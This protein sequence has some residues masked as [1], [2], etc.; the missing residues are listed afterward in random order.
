MTNDGPWNWCRDT[1]LPRCKFPQKGLGRRFQLQTILRSK[2]R[3]GPSLRAIITGD[4]V[5]VPAAT[6]R[7]LC[8]AVSSLWLRIS[9]IPTPAPKNLP[10]CSA[11]T[12]GYGIWKP[13]Y[14]TGIET[15]T[16]VPGYPFRS[17]TR[18]LV[19]PQRHPVLAL[20][21][22]HRAFPSLTSSKW[23]QTSLL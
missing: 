12:F 1:E 2:N 18:Q 8:S 6:W 3:A 11:R 14:T 23:F 15:S 17:N 7:A 13:R 19:L 16:R 22:L 20:H 9:V 10:G 4:G 21:S 5:Q